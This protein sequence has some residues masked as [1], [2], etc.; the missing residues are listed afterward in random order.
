MTV[1]SLLDQFQIS[2]E[3]VSFEGHNGWDTKRNSKLAQSL[4]HKPVF[5]DAK[6]R[7]YSKQ[8][9]FEYTILSNG[10]FN[11]NRF[12]GFYKH[13]QNRDVFDGYAFFLGSWDDALITDA[14]MDALIHKTHRATLDRHF[15]GIDTHY[16][17]LISEYLDERYVFPEINS[18]EALSYI[19]K[20]GLDFICSKVYAGIFLPAV[21]FNINNY[22]FFLSKKF[23]SPLFNMREGVASSFIGRNDYPGYIKNKKPLSLIVY[24]T[25]SKVYHRNMDSGISFKDIYRDNAFSILKMKIYKKKNAFI[26]KLHAHTSNNYFPQ[27][28]NGSFE[29]YP[30]YIEDET[31]LSPYL[32]ERISVINIVNDSLR[33]IK[34]LLK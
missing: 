24:R 9:I 3:L 34:H 28:K 2:Y 16:R 25:D 26:N 7:T 10:F 18:E 30:S 20:Y 6:G 23:F 19:Q 33:K 14:H 11:S 27:S 1:V 4:G 29:N 13:L 21:Y 15:K 31:K 22:S 12:Y 17:N 32:R 5:V 8:D